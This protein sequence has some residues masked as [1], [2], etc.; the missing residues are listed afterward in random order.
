MSAVCDKVYHLRN[1]YLV[2]KRFPARVVIG[3]AA[4]V[5]ELQAVARSGDGHFVA[6]VVV[7]GGVITPVRVDRGA[8]GEVRRGGG[9]GGV[10]GEAVG[11]GEIV[12]GAFREVEAVFRRCDVSVV[13][14]GRVIN[15]I[16]VYRYGFRS[17]YSMC[18]GAEADFV[19]TR[20]QNPRAAPVRVLGSHIF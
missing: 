14:V 5:H 19:V 16:A 15:N 8:E 2:Q 9:R 3:R 7:F 10:V 6:G 11:A 20:F 13:R 18:V 1:R 4:Q 12:Y 17:D